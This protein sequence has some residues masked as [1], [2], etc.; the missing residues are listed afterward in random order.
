MSN[1]VDK[2]EYYQKFAHVSVNNSIW[3]NTS[4]CQKCKTKNQEFSVFL[5][6]GQ[7]LSTLYSTCCSECLPLVINEA[8]KEGVKDAEDQIK[9]A[10]QRKYEEA[11][12]LV[13]KT[14][15]NKLEEK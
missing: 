12:K 11:I 3:S 2:R 15:I 4:K 6:E 5:G 14:K 10:E 1:E 9:R 13:R 7:R 8:I